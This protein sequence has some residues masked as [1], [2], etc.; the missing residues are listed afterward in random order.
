[1][2]NV[3]MEPY[4]LI[5]INIQSHQIHIILPNTKPIKYSKNINK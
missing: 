5:Q 1:M 2:I 3:H 4:I